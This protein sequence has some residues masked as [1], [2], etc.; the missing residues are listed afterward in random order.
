MQCLFHVCVFVCVFVLCVC[1]CVWFAL[2]SRM[3]RKKEVGGERRPQRLQYVSVI[4][5]EAQH[6]VLC[7]CACVCSVRDVHRIIES[8]ITHTHKLVLIKA[9]TEMNDPQVPHR[10]FLLP[11]PATDSKPQ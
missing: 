9:I 3:P 4:C 10:I 1:A 7:V 6:I 11:S 2:S 8:T 5:P